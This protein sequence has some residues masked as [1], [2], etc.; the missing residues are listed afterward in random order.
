[1]TK[2][3]SK[4]SIQF[5]TTTASRDIAVR[6]KGTPV[7]NNK[8]IQ[9]VKKPQLDNFT[10]PDDASDLEKLP[11]EIL[12]K[13]TEKIPD[14][15]GAISLTS[16]TLRRHN[17]TEH[18]KIGHDQMN[19]FLFVDS[20]IKS[21]GY[22]YI[23]DHSDMHDTKLA[24]VIRYITERKVEFYN[25]DVNLYMNPP[26]RHFE[27]MIHD[28]YPNTFMYWAVANGLNNLIPIIC[29]KSYP[30]PGVI[31]DSVVTEAVTGKR[32]D[33]AITVLSLASASLLDYAAV[34]G[35]TRII[36]SKWHF[37]SRPPPPDQ[38]HRF[39][40]ILQIVRSAIEKKAQ[41]FFPRI[42]LQEVRNAVLNYADDHLYSQD[43][44]NELYEGLNTM[45]DPV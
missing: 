25:Y 40:M 23:T 10:I 36:M 27:P 30:F 39:G 1:M 44:L 13:I 9:G 7:L 6:R 34:T 8:K 38:V 26:I 19:V 20:I 15:L 33:V 2:V 35:L 4:M 14:D 21:L 12:K 22:R 32:M 17:I 43:E 42:D 41:G 11:A 24:D 45:Y 3:E 5:N 29:D 16:Q 18:N 37:D 28:T 31:N